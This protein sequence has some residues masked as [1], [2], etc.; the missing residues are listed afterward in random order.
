VIEGEARVEQEEQQLPSFP[1]LRSLAVM[2]FR[3]I[4]NDEYRG[5][6]VIQE[7]GCIQVAGMLD[8]LRVAIF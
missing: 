3:G 6:C 2:V 4:G 7:R 1:V 8:H 5:R